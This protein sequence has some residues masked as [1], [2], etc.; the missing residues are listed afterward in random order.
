LT[1]PL[2][3]GIGLIN[4]VPP[5]Q[6]ESYD[7]DRRRHQPGDRFKIEVALTGWEREAIAAETVWYT[8]APGRPATLNQ[9]SIEEIDKRG[10]SLD[11]F[12]TDSHTIP[13]YAETLA[14]HAA[15]L[16]VNTPGL[17]QALQHQLRD[18]SDFRLRYLGEVGNIP[19]RGL[20]AQGSATSIARIGKLDSLP[21]YLAGFAG[22]QHR[23]LRGGQ[24]LLVIIEALDGLG[25]PVPMV[26]RRIGDGGDGQ[27]RDALAWLKITRRGGQGGATPSFLVKIQDDNHPNQLDY[28]GNILASAF[29]RTLAAVRSSPVGLYAF[30]YVPGFPFATPEGVPAITNEIDRFTHAREFDDTLPHRRDDRRA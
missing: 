3:N 11:R 13:V 20:F 27:G 24:A 18:H 2:D 29:G 26:G 6:S 9:L 12:P 14:S 8:I 1:T 19:F 25:N 21:L 28:N 23:N 4:Y 15:N 16:F 7:Y 5:G 22:D 30:Y 10:L 17:K